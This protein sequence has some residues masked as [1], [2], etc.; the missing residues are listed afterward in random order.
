MARQVRVNKDTTDID[1]RAVL[2]RYDNSA[3]ALIG[4]QIESGRTDPIMNRT[5]PWPWATNHAGEG[6]YFASAQEAI[7]WVAAHPAITAPI[8]ASRQATAPAFRPCRSA[9]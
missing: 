9:T 5:D 8:A 1:K 7:A 2:A 4:G 6:H 3:A